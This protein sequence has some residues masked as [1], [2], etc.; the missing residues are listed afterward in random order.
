MIDD[1]ATPNCTAMN[2]PDD[3]P[4]IELSLIAAL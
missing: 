4:E 1:Q 3:I 2:A